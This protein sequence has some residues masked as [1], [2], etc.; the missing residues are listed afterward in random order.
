[1]MPLKITAEVL[2]LM[3]VPDKAEIVPALDQLLQLEVAEPVSLVRVRSIMP[4]V[5]ALVVVVAPVAMVAAAAAAV[6]AAAAAAPVIS[7]AE[8][9]KKADQVGTG[10]MVLLVIPELRVAA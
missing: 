7:L 3:R 2:V 8:G 5:V 4:M 9:A 10:Q 6:A 1:M